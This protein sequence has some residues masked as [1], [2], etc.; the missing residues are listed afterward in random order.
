MDEPL[1]RLLALLRQPDTNSAVAAPVPAATFEAY[2]SGF[3]LPPAPPLNLPTNAELNGI[4]RNAG[5]SQEISRQ[6]TGPEGDLRRVSSI[7]TD[8]RL[9][10]ELRKMRQDQREIETKLFAERERMVRKLELEAVSAEILGVKKTTVSPESALRDV[11]KGIF[12]TLSKLRERQEA[13]LRDFAIF[14][15]LQGHQIR[16]IIGTITSFLET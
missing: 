6:A 12:Q 2:G 10:S 11:D 4:L 9:L 3:H 13:T 15:G 5:V 8:Q 1:E 16:A 14:H 7:L